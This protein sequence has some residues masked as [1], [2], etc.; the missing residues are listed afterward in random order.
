M[1]RKLNTIFHDL[2]IGLKQNAYR[3]MRRLAQGWDQQGLLPPG[4]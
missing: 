3:T 4:R 2:Q 1:A